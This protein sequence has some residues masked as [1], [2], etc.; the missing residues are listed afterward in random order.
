MAVGNQA[1]VQSVNGSLSSM[2]ITLRNQCQCI[3][4][5]QEFIT[6]LGLAGLEALGF[7]PTDAASVISYANYLNTIAGVFFGTATQAT[8]YNF[9]NQLAPLYAG[10]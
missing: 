3:V 7:S 6:Q 9:A 1:T 5:L 10:Q 4:N 2:A 8:Q